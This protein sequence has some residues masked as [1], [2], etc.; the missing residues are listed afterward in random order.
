MKSNIIEQ[1]PASIQPLC[2]GSPTLRLAAGA[3][4]AMP[5]YMYCKVTVGTVVQSAGPYRGPKMC[6]YLT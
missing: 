2:P 1:L 4:R 6:T 3:V 5:R